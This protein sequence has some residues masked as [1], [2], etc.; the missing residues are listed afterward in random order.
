MRNGEVTPKVGTIDKFLLSLDEGPFGALYR[1]AIGFVVTPAMRLLLGKDDSSWTLVPFLLLVLMLLR[2]GLAVVRKVAPFSE[3]LQEAWSV[4][5]RTAKAYDSYQWRKLVWI[6]AGL[7]CYV[8]A[9][10][11]YGPIQM[12]LSMFCL[13][14]GVSATVRWSVV[15]AD[16]KFPKPMARKTK[17][18]DAHIGAETYADA[19][20]KPSESRPLTM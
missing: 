9:S 1:V 10:G 2:V 15:S 13:V 14:A 20:A 8:A 5:R 18:R 4:R 12:A 3:E 6:G 7:A 19:N 11:R 17:R 16:G